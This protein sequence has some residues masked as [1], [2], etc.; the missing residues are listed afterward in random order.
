MASRAS[1]R[2]DEANGFSFAMAV[3]RYVEELHSAT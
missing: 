3:T 1:E 2:L